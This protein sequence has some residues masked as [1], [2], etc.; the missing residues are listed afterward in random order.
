LVILT[1]N[2]IRFLRLHEK[3]KTENAKPKTM[4]YLILLL[5]AP[6]LLFTPSCKKDPAGPKQPKPINLTAKAGEVISESNGFGI[7]LFRAAAVEE[8]QNMMLSPLSASTA[9][10]MLL[11]GCGTQTYV[12]I[13]DMLGYEGL[14]L[15]EINE[16]YNSLIGQ[17]LTVDPEVNL[18]L[19][20][21]VWY[22]KDFY[23]KEPFLNT[24]DS[25]FHSEVAAL[26]FGS[27]S[28]LE[29]INGWARD[30]TNGK[31]P[32]VLEVI[33]PGYVMFLMNALYFKGN[34]T[35]QFEESQTS[36]FPF[37]LANGSA[38]DVEMMRSLIPAKIS[39]E[40]GATAFELPYGQQNFAMVVI[41]P[42]EPLAAFLPGFD[43]ASWTGITN[44]LDSIDEP[45]EI[46][47]L[48][49]KFKFEY[50]KYLTDQLKALGMIDA[51]DPA[52]ADLSGIADSDIYVD[53]V[54]QN[55]FVDVNEKGTE[56]AAVTTIGIKEV[57]MPPTVTI[58]RP[59]IFAIRER[60]TNTLLFIGKLEQP[61]Y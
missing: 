41:L 44:S 32:K 5:L 50:E 17:L 38:V 31:I 19:A 21:A 24:M 18:A 36:G 61:L 46:E 49:P 39:Y 12:Q 2:F 30:N 58:D 28:A 51:F 34:W 45:A 6:I 54:K 11:N 9:I 22:S 53:F 14:T 47:V 27:P 3:C 48:L 20:N 57:S 35:Y 52:I 29:T 16:A 33:D 55:T 10:T 40:N 59:F 25:S 43:A 8:D 1:G 42:D 4:K 15:D 13:R 60:M 56:A 37:H 23:V 7:D 26:D